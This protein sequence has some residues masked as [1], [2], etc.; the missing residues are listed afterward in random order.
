[1]S[2][3]ASGSYLIHCRIVRRH[4]GHFS[5]ERGRATGTWRRVLRAAAPCHRRLTDEQAAVYGPWFRQRPP[6]PRSALFGGLT[7]GSSSATRTGASI[8]AAACPPRRAG[9]T[10]PSHPKENGIRTAVLPICPT[11]FLRI[12]RNVTHPI[13]SSKT[14]SSSTFLQRRCYAGS[15]GASAVGEAAHRAT[16]SVAGVGERWLQ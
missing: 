13:T 7:C 10:F 1:M 3:C 11:T 2:R 5:R 4:W 12:W 8:G 14:A 16:R 15:A 9:C 6:A